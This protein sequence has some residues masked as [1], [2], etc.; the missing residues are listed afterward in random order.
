MG[1]ICLAVIWLA[2]IWLAGSGLTL[3]YFSVKKVGL[4]SST[5][6]PQ[7]EGWFDST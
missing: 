3:T 4:S 6:Q 7:P 2:V 5:A 1:N